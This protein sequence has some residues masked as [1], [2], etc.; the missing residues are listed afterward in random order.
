[1]NC[2]VIYL[3]RKPDIQRINITSDYLI[4]S[5][6][7]TISI[8]D[9]KSDHNILEKENFTDLTCL[10]K[11]SKPLRVTS[12]E[13]CFYHIDINNLTSQYDYFYLIEDD[14]YSKEPDAIL[15]LIN[16]FNLFDA[17]LISKGIL[18]KHDSMEWNWWSR[19]EDQYEN[20]FKDPHKS[21]NPICRLSSKLIEII[22]AFK[23]TYNR[24]YF[25]EILFASLCVDNNLSYHDYT[26]YPEISNYIG[27]IH[28]RPKIDIQ[29]ITDS[30]IYHPVKYFFC[31]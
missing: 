2:L 20:V 18:P 6:I 24:F 12:W 29:E 3:C 22:L 21:F 7:D 26:Y 19:N 5:G 9:H 28:Y 1:M 31:G 27:K 13:K 30:K 16:Y 8:V 10:Y 25:H 14:V 11:N 15:S 23:Q 4:N 17:N